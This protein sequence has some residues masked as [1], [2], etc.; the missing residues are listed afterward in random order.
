MTNAVDI[1]TKADIVNFIIFKRRLKRQLQIIGYIFITISAI[2]LLVFCV[3]HCDKFVNAY[4]FVKDKANFMYNRVF[5]VKINK[6]VIKLQ[7]NSLLDKDEINEIIENSSV[8]TANREK[9]KQMIDKIKKSNA[10]I[11][12]VYARKILANG[13]LDIVIKEKPI[14]AVLTSDNCD[15]MTKKCKKYLITNK[16]EKLPYHELKSYD[17]VLKL[18]G[19][20]VDPDLSGI[21]QSLKTYKLFEKIDYLKFYN[22]GRFDVI[23][24]NRLTLKFPR[25]HWKQSMAKFVKLDSEFALSAD[26]QNISYIDLRR[27][28]KIYIGE[29]K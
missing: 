4:N 21:S 16:N 14:I 6:V 9:M 19:K 3:Y 24:R 5:D 12:D 1:S 2:A 29:K 11:D 23:L 27:V 18:Y 10:M 7:S 8:K 28:D 13:E 25:Q 15:D 17:N 22:S 20:L 26:P